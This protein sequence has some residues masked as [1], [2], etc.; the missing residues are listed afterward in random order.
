MNFADSQR[1]AE[2]QFDIVAVE[3][4]AIIAIAALAP[5]AR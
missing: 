4:K 1:L 5:G 2:D 3:T